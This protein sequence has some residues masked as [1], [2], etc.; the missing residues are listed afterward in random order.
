VPGHNGPSTSDADRWNHNIHYH[1]LLLAAIPSGA[2]R[3]LDVGCGEG[4]LA[5][6]LHREVPDV[7]GIDL[8]EAGIALARH[9]SEPDH[10]ITYVIGDFLT[11]P[12]K[13]ASFDAIV[14]VATLHFMEPV[15]ALTRLRELLTPGG[16]LA[17]VGVA[18]SRL[19]RDVGWEALA[20]ATNLRYRLSR[21]YWEH[22]CPTLWPPPNTYDTTRR[23][24]AAQLPGA[25][26]RR[27]A[28]WR[29][30]FVWTK[31]RG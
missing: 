8:D 14:S 21:P 1:R 31:P 3:V 17:V 11:H 12:F 15:A 7:T 25:R 13:P 23:V 27:H 4:T 2:Q 20:A 26:F 16:V 6:A 10:G 5:R 18:R 19:P 30:S 24:V 29:Y 9:Q 28:L 22:P